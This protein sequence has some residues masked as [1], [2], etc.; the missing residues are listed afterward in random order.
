M[1]VVFPPGTIVDDDI[2][3]ESYVICD[4]GHTIDIARPATASIFKEDLNRPANEMELEEAAQ[5]AEALADRH[6][7]GRSARIGRGYMVGLDPGI[8]TVVVP[9][10][11]AA[12]PAEA[13]AAFHGASAE[14]EVADGQE[15]WID[16]PVR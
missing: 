12:T 15:I 10:D 11:D 14:V 5:K 6:V 7:P 2:V 3:E 4:D 1:G 8:Y 16:I 9:K 13:G